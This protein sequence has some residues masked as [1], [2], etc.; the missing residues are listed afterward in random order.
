MK[1]GQLI[2]H[3]LCRERLPSHHSV[4]SKG[5]R[6]LAARDRRYYYPGCAAYIMEKKQ[7]ANQLF[8]PSLASN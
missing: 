1:L 5:Q 7:Q 2:F 6:A 3:H 8:T 4:I